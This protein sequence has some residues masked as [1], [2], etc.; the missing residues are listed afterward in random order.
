MENCPYI[1]QALDFGKKYNVKL[2][3]I[4]VAYKPYFT[5]DKVSRYVFKLKLSRGRK[6]FTFEFGQSIIN[7]DKTPIL[8]DVLSCLQ[9]YEV[10]SFKNFCSE[11]GYEEMDLDIYKINK[12]SLKIYK[13][14]CKEFDNM[15][16]LFGDVMEELQ[17]I[18]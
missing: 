12:T 17:E 6:S 3:V 13:S 10:G 9:K 16:K 4:S 2:S 1:T 18:Q 5:N 8:Y 7:G 14:V 11:F 15:E